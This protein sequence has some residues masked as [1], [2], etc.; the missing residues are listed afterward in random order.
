MNVFKHVDLKSHDTSEDTRIEIR[1]F[2][3]F[4]TQSLS[5]K[6]LCLLCIKMNAYF[7]KITYIPTNK[8]QGNCSAATLFV[9]LNPNYA[10]S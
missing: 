8:F 4:P 2:C 1:L 7:F 10:P 9:P 6:S 3:D 5:S